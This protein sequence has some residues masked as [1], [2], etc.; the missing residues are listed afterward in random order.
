MKKIKLTL[1]CT[2][3]VL[4]ICAQEKLALLQE[5]TDDLQLLANENHLVGF[6]LGIYNE[7]GAIYKN[8][9]GYSDLAKKKPYTPNTLQNIGSISK[10]FIGIALLKAQEQGK[11]DIDDPIN[12][13]LPFKIE[14]PHHSNETITIRHLVTHSSSINDRDLWYG[15]NSYILK[16]KKKAGEKKKIFFSKPEDMLSLKEVFEIYLVEGGKGYKKKNFSKYK[17][18]TQY[19][20]SNIASA[21]AAYIV[22][23]ATGEDFN[24][25]TQKH[26]FD[27]LE[28][29][30]TGWHF[31]DIDLEQYTSLYFKS[32]K[33]MTLYSLA[34]YPDG[35]LITSAN[36]MIKYA[37]E[38]IKGFKGK[39]T[40]IEEQSYNEAFTGVL[41]EEQLAQRGNDDCG[42]FFNVTDSNRIGHSGGDPGITTI[43]YFDAKTGIGCY[44]QVNSEFNKKGT[45]NIIAIWNKLRE[46]E[47]K[48][49]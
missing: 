44:I 49:N 11:L 28:M 16:E 29:N 20:Y 30:S 40:L 23:L 36:D 17:P 2:L 41:T 26:I 18:G 21:L 22:E 7:E 39:G 12:K 19:K 46:Y 45:Q 6:S 47:S 9:F 15:F 34:T 35:G 48:F 38:I 5:L 8:A 13:Y 32:K 31:D 27:P 14:N 24:Q 3:C 33:K 1:L 25:Y 37:S 42:V 43:M 10:T 4:F